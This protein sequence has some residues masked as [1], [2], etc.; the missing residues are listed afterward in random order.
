MRSSVLSLALAL[1]T[2]TYADDATTTVPYFNA[3]WDDSDLAIPS[4]SGTAASVV[5]VNAL[6]TTYE[7]GCLDDAPTT[8]CSIKDPQTVINGISTY[9]FSGVYTALM[10]TPALTVT[11]EMAC[12]FTSYSID[13]GCS[14]SLSIHGSADGSEVAISTSTETTFATGDV[15]S[16]GML[17]TGGVDKLEEPEATETPGAAGVAAGP[18]GAFVTAAPV[19]AAGVV[20]ML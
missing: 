1:A 10:Q 19:L 4:Y 3:N 2:L 17:V 16:Y 12:S 11:R 9:S 6:E 18:F 14:F 13:A 5:S 15:T 20:A 8:L 7:V